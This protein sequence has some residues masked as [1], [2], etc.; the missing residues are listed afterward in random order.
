MP[1]EV[2]VSGVNQFSAGLYKEVA[3]ADIAARNIVTKGA[4]VIKTEAKKQFRPTQPKTVKAIP[5]NPTN[6]TGDLQRSIEMQGTAVPQGRG[7][8]MSKTGSTISY[9]GYVE[10]G[11]TRMT[12]SPYPV[13]YPYM[14]PGLLKSEPAIFIIAEE[15]WRRAL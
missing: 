5:I 14:K 13:G 6:R 8:W 15:E 11:T 7:V 2:V 4:E 10:Y 1:F 9:A 3:K 12:Q